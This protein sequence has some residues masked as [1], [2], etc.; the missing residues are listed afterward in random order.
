MWYFVVYVCDQ[1]WVAILFKITFQ[2][3]ILGIQY[4]ICKNLYT[5]ALGSVCASLG[6]TQRQ[7]VQTNIFLTSSG[8]RGHKYLKTYIYIQCSTSILHGYYTFSM[9]G[10]WYRWESKT[11]TMISSFSLVFFLIKPKNLSVKYI[12]LFKIQ[13]TTRTCSKLPSR[14]Q[15]RWKC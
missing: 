15:R 9:H 10:W 5:I 6:S 11:K 14:V 3:S 4:M 7:H 12:I 2:A 1:R 13:Q 8:H